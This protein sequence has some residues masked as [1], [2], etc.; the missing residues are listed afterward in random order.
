MTTTAPASALAFDLDAKYTQTEGT[1]LLSGVQALVR[2]PLDQIRADRRQQL[3]TAGL[4][5]GYRGSPLAGLDLLI[6]K[7]GRHLQD[8]QI[9]FIPGVNEDLGATMIFGSQIANLFPQPKYDG[10]IGMWYGKA[11]G[12]D[13]SGDIF[14]HA[15]AAGTGRYGGVLVVAGDD[16]MSKS[17]TLP[18]ASETALYDALMPVLAP[19]NIQ[20]VLDLGRLGFE[21]SRYSGL[22]VGFKLSNLVAEQFSTAQVGLDRLM[23]I[24]PEL[25]INGRPWQPTQVHTLGSPTSLVLEQEIHEGRL[26][27]AQAFAAA[28]R[29]NQ[30][31]SA[32]IQARIGLVAAGKPYYE[33]RQALL[34]LGLDDAALEQY[35]IR[36]LKVGMP[37]PLD[38][39]LV[40]EF[41]RGLH[42]I[43]VVEEK[44]AFMELFIRDALYDRSDRPLVV[45][46][47]DHEQRPLFPFHGELDA[48]T[49]LP[50]IARRLGPFVPRELIDAAMARLHAQQSLPVIQLSAG[51][52]ARTAYFC[53]GCPHNRSTVVPEGS[54]AGGGIGC[55]G[56]V[57]AMGRNTIGLG[58]M[59]GEGAQ[60]AGIAPFS[61]M[62]HLFQNLGDGTLFHSGSLAIRQAI[63][64]GTTITYK[65]LYN[66]AVG[67]TGGQSVDGA[68][69]VAALTRSLEAEGVQRIIVTS[70]DPA[71]YPADTRWAPGV[72]VWHRDRL[73]E[74]QLQLREIPG[75]TVLIHDQM[76]AAERRRLR[77][78]G[79]IDDP[80]TRVVINEAIC[81]GC[82]DCGAKSNCLS[83]HPIETEYGRKTQIHQSSCNK[84][85]SCL[86]GDCPAFTTVI[87]DPKHSAPTRK[88][89][90]IPTDLP[91]PTL[92]VPEACNIAMMGIGGT[93]V[94]T[95]NQILGTAALLDQRHVD[96]L[97][98]TG[99]SQKGGPVISHLK[100]SKQPISG[101]NRITNGQ[102][103]CFL[104]FDLL[105]ATTP[106]NLARA[107]PQRTVAVISTSQ[108]PTG[109]M[110]AN[111]SR[112]FPTVDRLLESV[113]SRTRAA[114][115]FQ[116]DAFDLAERAFGDHLAANVILLGAAFQHGCIPIAAAA[117]E[118]AIT[119]NGTAVSMNMNAFRLGRLAVADPARIEQILRPAATTAQAQPAASLDQATQALIDSVGASGELLRL[120]QVRVPELIAYQ[121]RAYAERYIALVRSVWQAE[122]QAL[123]G[124]AAL[125][126]A[127]ARS[128]FK[129]MAYKDE[130]EVARLA[131]LPH[132]Q[133]QITEQY[134]ANATLTYHLHPPFLRT[135]G[136]QQKIAFGRWFE[137]GFRLLRTM[138]RLRGTPFDPFGYAH[139]RK[140]ERQLINQYQQSII[141]VITHL[142][143][144]NHTDAIRMAQLPDQIRGY[145]AI[146]LKGIEQFRRSL[147]EL[148]QTI[149][150][151]H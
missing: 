77:K 22:W 110:V 119:L 75:V 67:M 136:W 118:Q 23:I 81:E 28:N 20:D 25:Q 115:V 143:P 55:H 9:R 10:V 128:M 89:L 51:G 100:I 123:P 7:A 117:I 109:A 46:K 106:V 65:I 149:V 32:G 104:A 68:M 97:D 148:E 116:L 31:V 147:A 72:E 50:L 52:V 56:L 14:K 74:A 85:Y 21:L 54:L 16:P 70:E 83:V 102:A 88:R 121:D 130:Y 73:D 111:P 26:V 62:P 48:D 124:Q 57:H 94:V 129:L 43:V 93:G 13:R 141:S 63:A 150:R 41:A 12:V 11:P 64:A 144:V 151:T 90:E 61:D 8:H 99:L 33:L 24:R 137:V 103:D 60:W 49:I 34:G 35:G 58:H 87:P 132:F 76:C 19:G 53:S 135:L 37:F 84:D 44:R 59:G 105:T 45:G 145:E 138:K 125:S 36:I 108:V 126:E 107:H 91:T 86:M 6:Q 146:K 3:N 79:Q 4:I 5:S 122:Q 80:P 127:V 18:S 40:Q 98:Q 2:L 131:L 92:R 139:L 114:E 15:N 39:A 112:Q 30:I 1:I 140:I 69:S 134:G 120:L 47:Y 38:R 82:G 78:R 95:V 142:N 29:I 42:E 27:A 113:R 133:Q 66:A 17:S 101:T 71:Q 96:G